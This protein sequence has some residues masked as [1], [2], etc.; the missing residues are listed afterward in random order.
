MLHL[1]VEVELTGCSCAFIVPIVWILSCRL[2][3]CACVQYAV[4]KLK[5][6]NVPILPLPR[7]TQDEDAAEE[8]S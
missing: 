5:I 6:T 8:A 4:M 7:L 1:Q 2:F 3:V